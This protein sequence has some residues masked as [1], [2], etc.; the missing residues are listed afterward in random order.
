MT[1]D[2]LNKQTVMTILQQM[3]G[4]GRLVAMTGAWNFLRGNEENG[5][6]YL[7]FRFKASKKA[8]YCKVTYCQG[9]DLYKVEF[10]KIRMPNYKKVS[11]HE[12]IYC[13]MLIELFERETG[14]YLHF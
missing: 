7:T 12:G 1:Q 13:D 3:G 10:G 2:E 5:N 11:E 9:D 14:L 6:P 8:N 4:T